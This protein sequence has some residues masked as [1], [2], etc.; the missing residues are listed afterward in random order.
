MKLLQLEEKFQKWEDLHLS[1]AF[2]NSMQTLTHPV[3]AEGDNALPPVILHKQPK[4]TEST[5]TL[6]LVNKKGLAASALA[7]TFA[8][9]RAENNR[10]RFEN[11]QRANSLGGS[12]SKSSQEDIE[13]TLNSMIRP[14]TTSS[15]TGKIRIKD[16]AVTPVSKI[17]GKSFSHASRTGQGYIFATP[18]NTK[19]QTDDSLT[20]VLKPNGDAANVIT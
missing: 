12:P 3:T 6:Q 16:F 11:R 15:P 10:K 2:I 13:E 20:F 18:K 4:N 5:D 8:E 17:P 14:K 19:P 9:I 1:E 7:S